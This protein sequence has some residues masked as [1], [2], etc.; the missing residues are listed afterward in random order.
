MRLKIGAARELITPALGGL[1]AGYGSE[2]PS[3]AVH[4]DL[5]ATAIIFECG[6]TRAML[7]SATV[8]LIG[9][10]LSERVR[11]E[12]GAAA[13][14]P[15]PNVILA[16]THTHSGPVMSGDKA[17]DYCEAIFA[18]RCA[19]AAAAASKNLIPVTMGVAATKSL[20][21]INRR[22]LLPDDK[23]ILGQNPW[24][25]YDPEMTVISFRDESGATVANIIH[26][27]AHCTAAGINTE[28]TRDWAGVMIDRLEQ[29]SGAITAFFNG[30]LGDVAPRMANG[31][32]TGDIQHAM[33]VGGLAGIDAVRAYKDIRAWRDE[34][35]SIA[36][37]EIRIPYEPIMPLDE[38]RTALAEYRAMPDER[39]VI[40]GRRRLERIIE[41]HESGAAGD[42]DFTHP[43][44]IVN[45]GPVAFVPIPFEPFSEISLRLRAY[46]PIGHTLAI[47]CANGSNS[48]LPTQDQLC[49]GGYEVERFMWGAPR[50]LPANTDAHIVNQNLAM[51]NNIKQL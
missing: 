22:Q 43:Q 19:A 48:Y 7:I 45:I 15:V 34:A 6:G 27:S 37:G 29:E 4:D 31:G 32:S 42:A 1:F 35:M 8:C 44:V 21:G 13:G 38:A 39:F 47:G 18:P 12:C 28:V 30:A 46:S 25:T 2:K 49:R 3:T 23:V 41:L 14:V 11:R 16:S 20:V 50:Q 24:G 36:T 40:S 9:S 17:G 10:E 33:E 5:T 51:L 26:C